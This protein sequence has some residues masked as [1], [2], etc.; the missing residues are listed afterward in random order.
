VVANIL[1]CLLDQILRRLEQDFLKEGGRRERMT[2][3][4]LNARAKRQR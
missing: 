4:R 1:I 2:R 3:A